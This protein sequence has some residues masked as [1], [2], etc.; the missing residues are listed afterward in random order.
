MI[1]STRVPALSAC[2]RIQASVRDGREQL[3]YQDPLSRHNHQR[4]NQKDRYGRLNRQEPSSLLSLT[5]QVPWIRLQKFT[6]PPVDTPPKI[7][8]RNKV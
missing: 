4:A 7:T 3:S 1:A 5:G 2:A 6:P 8:H